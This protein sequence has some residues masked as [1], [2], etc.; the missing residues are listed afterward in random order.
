[1]GNTDG[2][3]PLSPRALLRLQLPTLPCRSL[4]L[5]EF[6]GLLVFSQ[7]LHQIWDGM[8][9]GLLQPP[10]GRSSSPPLLHSLHLHV[11]VA[12][13]CCPS[14]GSPSTSYS[15][16]LCFS[17][18]LSIFALP[19][20]S[21]SKSQDLL[22]G[23]LLALTTLSIS[24][25][26]RMECKRED[27]LTVVLASTPRWPSRAPCLG[28]QPPAACWEWCALLCVPL[29]GPRD[30]FLSSQPSHLTLPFFFFFPHLLSPIIT[31]LRSCFQEKKKEQWCY[32]AACCL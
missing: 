6:S 7:D 1:M 22:A 5:K 21:P 23:I 11:R 28:Q 4:P 10:R 3:F 8:Q 9:P 31:C 20:Q 14:S 16:W 18:H 27:A 32:K 12:T 19:I 29:W 13:P 24:A 30:T 2:L 25:T 15:F 26:R 17:P